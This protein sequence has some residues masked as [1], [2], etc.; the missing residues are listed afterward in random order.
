MKK[1]I[2]VVMLVMALF[3]SISCFAKAPWPEPTSGPWPEPPV[4]TSSSLKL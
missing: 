1:A 3:S 2:F 4:L